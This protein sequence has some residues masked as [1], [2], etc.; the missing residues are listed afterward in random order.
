MRMEIFLNFTKYKILIFL[1][2]FNALVI[3]FFSCSRSSSQLAG[4]YTGI[5]TDAANV[6]SEHY[7]QLFNNGN[8][9]DR[10]IKYLVPLTIRLREG[11][12][13]LQGAMVILSVPGEKDTRYIWEHGYLRDESAS[14]A[15]PALTIDMVSIQRI[16]Q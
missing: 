6:R 3:L 11:N 14:I 10:E 13:N 12:W 9:I 2:V 7:L 15:H 16:G 1:F 4:I 8:F 5:I